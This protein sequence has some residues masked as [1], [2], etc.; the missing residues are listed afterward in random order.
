MGLITK[1]FVR[2]FGLL[3]EVLLFV[4][5]NS[6]KLITNAFF[7]ELHLSN[8]MLCVYW[9]KLSYGSVDS[10]PAYFPRACL[11]KY[12]CWYCCCWSSWRG[13]EMLVYHALFVAVRETV[14]MAGLD[15]PRF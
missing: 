4:C 8:A 3:L 9:V 6:K 2:R 7:R 12:L 10:G 14:W 15:V 1:L 11:Q 13:E 5:W